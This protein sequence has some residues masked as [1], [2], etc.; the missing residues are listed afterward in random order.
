MQLQLSQSALLGRNRLNVALLLFVAIL[1]TANVGH[2]TTA[3]LQN[4]NSMAEFHT[5]AADP[6]TKGLFNWNVDGID[7]I[8]EQWFWY[9]V[10]NTGPES[11]LD[12]LT[13]NEVS[14]LNLDSEAGNDFLLVGYVDPAQRFSI[15]VR[16]M[17]TGG[18]TGSLD[19]DLV[20]VLRIQNLST[21]QPLDFHFFQYVDFD[22]GGTA[23][24]DTVSVGGIPGNTVRQSDALLQLSETVVTPP[25]SRYAVTGTAASL[26]SQLTDG[27]PTSLSGAGGPITGDAAWAFQWDF[28]L[29]PGDS[30]LISK[31]KN[32]RPVP[33]PATVW[34][35]FAAACALLL[36][37]RRIRR[38][39]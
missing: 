14:Q 26:K 9:R 33:E 18:T 2:A 34:T 1:L 22:L 13:Q 37:A 3:V 5:E 15:Q 30:Y 19:S 7:Q 28:V 24:D 27:S 39:K 21:T 10:G 36:A 38:N 12:T 16:Y 32:L 11:A 25:P 31:D 17:L 4:R 29:A 35:A 6:G 8:F 23:N 20:E